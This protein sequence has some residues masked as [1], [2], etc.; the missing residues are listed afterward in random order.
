MTAVRCSYVLVGARTRVGAGGEALQ[1]LALAELPSG[2]R[3]LPFLRT[4][5][6][7]P[8]WRWGAYDVKVPLDG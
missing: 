3:G 5:G 6:P 4:L 1:R 7:S 2:Q 8:A